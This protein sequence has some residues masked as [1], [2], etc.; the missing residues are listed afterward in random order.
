MTPNSAGLVD[1]PQDRFARE[2]YVASFRAGNFDFT[3]ITVHFPFDTQERRRE[4]QALDDV[5]EAVQ[6][7]NPAE[8]DVLLMGDFNLS[9]R[10][11]A[12]DELKQ[13]TGLTWTLNL[14]TRTSIGPSGMANLYDNMWF[15]SQFLTEYTG[16]SGTNEFMHDLFE[17]DIYASA[18]TYVSDHVPIYAV[19]RTNRDDDD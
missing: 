14:P 11:T 9:S 16:Q 15:Q 6:A 1:D 4:A 19:F 13:V 10:N 5:F 7:A 2:P 18:R 17:D 8:N 3:L 12:W